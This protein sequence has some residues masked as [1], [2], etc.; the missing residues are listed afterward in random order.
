MSRE[1]TRVFYISLMERRAELSVSPLTSKQ[2]SQE[3]TAN[4]TDLTQAGDEHSTQKS[5]K[6]MDDKCQ[7]KRKKTQNKIKLHKTFVNIY[8]QLQILSLFFLLF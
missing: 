2:C 1:K 3:N 7:K 5:A 8:L 6:Y 4:N